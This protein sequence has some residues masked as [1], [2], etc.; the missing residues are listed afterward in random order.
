MIRTDTV[1]PQCGST[2]TPA[3]EKIMGQDT[4]DLICADCGH[5]TW[6]RSFQ[7]S[8]KGD[9]KEEKNSMSKA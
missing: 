8:V 4:M 2:K 9:S 5:T 3:K 1:C 7:P 6:W